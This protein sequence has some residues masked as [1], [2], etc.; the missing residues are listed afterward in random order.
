MKT[1]SIPGGLSGPPSACASSPDRLDV[2]AAGPGGTVWRW[3]KDG[4]T[5]LPSAPLP[6]LGS[7]PAEGVCAV[8]SAEGR[9]EVFAVDAGSRTPMWWRGNGT[10]WGTGAALI[11]GANLQSVPVAAVAASPDDIDV[12]AV[13]GDRTPWWWHWNGSTWTPPARLPDG[14]SLSAVRLA[15]VSPRPGRLD[16]FAVG[17]NTHLWHW[18]K[19]GAAPWALEDL[20]GSMPA[21]GVSAVSWARGRIDV[22]AASR[23]AGNPLLH[24]WTDGAAFAGP[25]NLGGS[26]AAGTVSAVSHAPFRLDV[27]GIS[28]DQRIAQW[29]WNGYGWSGPNLRGEGVPAG[30]VSA[31]VRLPHRLDVFVTGA[32]GTLRAWPGGGLEN[33][34]TGPWVNWPSNH[35][36]NPAGRLRPDNLDEL[37]AIVQ[38][39]ERLGRGVRAV[40]SGWSNSDV[41]VTTGY[42]VETDLL[43]AFLN[44]VLDTS[45]NAA[46]AGRRLV[47]MEAGI[48]LDVLIDALTARG[49]ELKTLGG[50]SGQSLAGAV[51]TGVH[52][53]DLDRGPL[54]HMVRAIHLVG[55]GGVQ[56]WIEPSK[57]I[58]ER[59][60]L[61]Q[62]LGL[63]D[64]NIHYDDDWFGS[65][66]VSMGSLGIIYSLVLEVDTSYA[67][68]QS[69]TK[70]DW[71]AIRARMADS[72]DDLLVGNRGVQVALSPYPRGDGSRGCYLTTR[73]EAPPDGLTVP[74]DEPWKAKLFVPVLIDSFQRNPSLIDDGVNTITSEEQKQQ[75]IS[76]W[77][78]DLVGGSDP[79][80]N[81]G[82]TV[83][84]FF[85]TSTT[86]YLDFVDAA[87]E[88]L[89]KAYYDERPGRSYL[90]WISMRFQGRSGA[91]L[92]PHHGASRTCTVEFAAVWQTR[93]LAGPVWWAD[94]PVLLALIEAEGRK[95]GGV[96][97]WG[98][99]DDVN[100]LDVA[101]AYSRL[102]TWRRVRW[103]LTR[104]STL[105]TFDSDFTRRCGLSDPPVFVRAGD[106]D[107]DGRTNHAVWRPGSGTW[108]ILNG[109]GTERIVQFGEVGD[110]P[111]PGDYDGDGKAD[112]GVWRPRDGTW[113]IDRSSAAAPP[114]PP[115]S[116]VIVIGAPPGVLH[117]TP[118]VAPA[119]PFV[120]WGQAG[121]VPVP[122]DYD[123]DGKTDLAVWRPGTGEWF[124]I[125]SSTGA[126]RSR[127]WG[128][129]GDIPV[130]GDYDGDGKT[131]FAVWRPSTGM[132]LVIDSSN[133]AERSQQWGQRGDVPVPADYSGDGR[134]DF[135]IWRPGDGQWWIIDIATGGQRNRQ[136]GAPS[137]I[138]VPGDYDSDGKTD[139]AVWRS[140]T[141]TWWIVDSSTGAERGVKWGQFGDVPV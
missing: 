94:T 115:G 48:K 71:T 37:V 139:I 21:E 73:N 80:E 8:S 126:R 76:S 46:A 109:A 117:P 125:D 65:V 12:F 121:D 135:A 86:T 72:N 81:K 59:A 1:F 98:M 132:W 43:S 75:D 74:A 84:F 45:M 33:A 90:G 23:A 141:G 99:N 50:S 57:P 140:S 127:Q 108:V 42:V 100:T 13:G 52:G 95:F 138:P 27:F 28:G 15:A 119:P 112:L 7:I 116:G 2:F 130:P 124:V 120:Q 102:D 53:M 70:V 54:P 129:P 97:H 17:A 39:A 105:A 104:G 38:E 26:L 49:L 131:D 20:G 133:G 77:A 63:A 103:E 5:W 88:I 30:D 58:T 14:A 4:T 44:D 118:P 69:R 114:P 122:G 91:Y 18:R 61:K 87:L 25:E 67:L 34:S 10:T 110:I 78:H 31:V 47:H 56:H 24:W 40:G 11:T 66:L 41:A 93:N 35:P 60:A 89:R 101:R 128:Q 29:H 55:P 82:L 51:S 22:F 16:V 136:W 113:W 92:S 111:V 3:S 123:G 68:A 36:T 6:A 106:F 32:G 9:V 62:A 137:D 107:G 85:D 83:E 64:G 134:T 79:G 19:D 96:Q